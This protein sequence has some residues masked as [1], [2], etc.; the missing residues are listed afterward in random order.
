MSNQKLYVLVK[1]DGPDPSTRVGNQAWQE[2]T[3]SMEAE[4][5]EVLTHPTPTSM[6]FKKKENGRIPRL[7]ATFCIEWVGAHILESV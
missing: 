1:I 2:V 4:G 3:V 7:P 6:L 5:W